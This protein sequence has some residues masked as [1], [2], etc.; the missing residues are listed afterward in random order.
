[1]NN[2][3]QIASRLGSFEEWTE[4]EITYLIRELG[5]GM[6]RDTTDRFEGYWGA[7][8]ALNIA[9]VFVSQGDSP[10]ANEVAVAWIGALVAYA[11]DST[12]WGNE[13][14]PTNPS[15][16]D[17]EYKTIVCAL[18]MI[19]HAARPI[20]YANGLENLHHGEPSA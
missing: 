9:S 11:L 6:G 2:D 12:Y 17:P 4:C 1:M 8:T 3:Q 15:D 14:T 18:T 20:Q 13:T 5:Y 16:C 7:H 10:K 19:E